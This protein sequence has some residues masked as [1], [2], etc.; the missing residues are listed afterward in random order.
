MIADLEAKI[1][2]NEFK[3]NRNIQE[4]K[5]VEERTKNLLKEEKNKCDR[6]GKLAKERQEQ[7][8]LLSIQIKDVQNQ[9]D[10]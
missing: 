1:K 3:H 6:I 2:K 4:Y 7:N 5:I 10:N 9:R 8:Q